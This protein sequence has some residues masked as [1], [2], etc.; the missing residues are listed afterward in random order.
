MNDK[1]SS[2]TTPVIVLKGFKKTEVNPS[3]TT[4]V[5]FSVPCTELA[6]WDK[7]MNYVIEPGEFEI[8]IGA[9][10]DDI[11]VKETIKLLK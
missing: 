6:L 5:N 7:E 1:I 10:S 4:T 3:Q 2:V 9:S 11:R 8:M